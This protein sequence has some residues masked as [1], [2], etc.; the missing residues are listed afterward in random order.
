MGPPHVPPGLRPELF[1]LKI[2]AK[3]LYGLKCGGQ[4]VPVNSDL[5]AHDEQLCEHAVWKASGVIGILNRS[6]RGQDASVLDVVSCEAEDLKRIALYLYFF[7]FL[8]ALFQLGQPTPSGA[9]AR[10]R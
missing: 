4:T 5:Q 10:S 7:E 2:L 6:P 3:C 8:K 1:P 9:P